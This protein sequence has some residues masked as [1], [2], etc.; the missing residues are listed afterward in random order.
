MVADWQ[1]SANLD[2]LRQRAALLMQIRSFFA[3]AEVLEVDTPVLGV[4]GVTEPNIDNVV[5]Q[6]NGERRYLQS[7]PEYFMKRLLA[8]GSG[9]I[10]YLGKVFRD[11]ERG[12][13]HNPE[14]TL[15]EWY[16]PGWDEYQLMAEIEQ[17]FSSLSPRWRG[18][19]RQLSYREAFYSATGFDPHS[20]D[21]RVLQQLASQAC[22]GDWSL[23]SR[24][25]CLDLLFSFVVEP[26]LHAGMVMIR[27]YPACQSALAQLAT[28]S[29]GVTVARRF[30]VFVDGMEI[31][32]GYFE[33]TDAVEQRQRFAA[34]IALREA[35]GK[36]RRSVDPALLAALEAGL[37]VGAGVAI[38][39]DR[40]LMRMLDLDHIGAV[41]PFVC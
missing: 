34:D 9:P 11:G 6:V 24:A 23:E 2:T 22:S 39:V 19:A 38:G 14:F 25:T 30:E 5:A 15:L 29:E 12:R 3:A 21:L 8:A 20:T 27:D 18:G 35:A 16:R 32:N 37:P 17:L 31:G 33:L 36:P 28:D 41:L 4:H 1:P 26:T 10:Y 13:R 7:S 40:L